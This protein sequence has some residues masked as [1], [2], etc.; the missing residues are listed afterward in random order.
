MTAKNDVIPHPARRAP[1]LDTIPNGPLLTLDVIPD[2]AQRRAGIQT[3]IPQV[4]A[5]RRCDWIPA[6]AGMT[7]KSDVIPDGPLLLLMSSRMARS[8][9]P[10]L[11]RNTTSPQD[12]ATRTMIRPQ[13]GIARTLRTA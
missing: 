11:S 5:P 10:G 9:E 6:S 7:A 2:G 8:A 4:P 3:G 12:H 13:C 1:S